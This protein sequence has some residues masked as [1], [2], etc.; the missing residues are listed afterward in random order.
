MTKSAWKTATLGIVLLLTCSPLMAGV[1]FQVETTYHSGSSSREPESSQM[2]VEGMNLKM[3]TV[4]RRDRSA[5]TMQDEMIFRGDSDTPYVLAIRHDK[6]EITKIDEEG[7][8]TVSHQMRGGMGSQMDQAMKDLET[9]LQGLDPKQR[10]MV[11]KMLKERMGS[12]QQPPTMSQRQPQQVLQTSER[13][14]KHNYPC[15]KYD[16]MQGGAKIRELWVTDW[17]NIRHGQEVRDAFKQMAAFQ[18]KLMEAFQE[19]HGPGAGWFG[20]GHDPMAVFTQVDGFPVVT[21]SFK[22]GNLESETVLGSVKERALGPDDFEPPSGYRMRTMG[23][24]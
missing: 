13:A 20:A 10:D 23:P 5:G 24:Q 3:Q 16:V 18:R 2:L 6:Q 19:A 11:A 14:T 21:R 12:M 8:R 17:Q 22:D 7:M 15:V 4:P 1:V 9:K